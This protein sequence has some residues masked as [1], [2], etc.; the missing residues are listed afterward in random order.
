MNLAHRMVFAE[1]HETFLQ[2]AAH[3][4]HGLHGIRGVSNTTTIKPVV[5]TGEL[6][7]DI[8]H[9]LH[10]SWFFDPDNIQVTANGGKVRLTGTVQS[11]HERQVAAATAWSAFGV[12]AVDNAI[13]VV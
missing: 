11:P 9:A 4:V 5:N 12:V 6:S 7:D 1:I 2:A 10:R 8:T 3:D 13:T